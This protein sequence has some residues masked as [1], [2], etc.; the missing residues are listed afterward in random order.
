MTKDQF[1]EWLHSPLTRK[2]LKGLTD[3][4][5]ELARQWASGVEMSPLTQCKAKIWGRLASSDED[6]AFEAW[7]GLPE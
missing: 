7:F 2:A 5:Q 3:Q 4:Q 6:E 1:L